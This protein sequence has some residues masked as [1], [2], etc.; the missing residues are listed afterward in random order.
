M[1]VLFYEIVMILI[2]GRGVDVVIDF[3]GG[4]DGNELVFFLCLN[5]YFLMIGFLLGI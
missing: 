4:L 3:I 2:N 1:I 5:G